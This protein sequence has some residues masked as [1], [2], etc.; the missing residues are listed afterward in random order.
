MAKQ[1]NKYFILFC[2][3]W[4]KSDSQMLTFMTHVHVFVCIAKIN[5]SKSA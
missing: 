3:S 4:T 2:A 1:Q 5:A